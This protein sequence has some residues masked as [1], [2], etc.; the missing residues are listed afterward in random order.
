MKEKIYEDENLPSFERYELFDI[1]EDGL[2]PTLMFSS[3]YKGVR[4]I[5]TL[6]IKGINKYNSHTKKIESEKFLE[7]YLKLGKKLFQLAIS[8]NKIIFHLNKPL[9]DA[10]FISYYIEEIYDNDQALNFNEKIDIDILTELTDYLGD[11]I[12]SFTEILDLRDQL[13]DIGNENDFCK[14]IFITVDLID[15]IINLFIIN[16]TLDLDFSLNRLLD[17]VKKIVDKYY[18]E[19]ALNNSAKILNIFLSAQFDL[20][21]LLEEVEL[22]QK[23]KG[24]ELKKHFSISN[25]T[26][27]FQNMGKI[28]IYNKFEKSP[29]EI[30]FA[31]SQLKDLKRIIINWLNDY[32]F[33]YYIRKKDEA[34]YRKNTG[35]R[36]GDYCIPCNLLITNSIFSYMVYTIFDDWNVADI[37]IKNIFGFDDND[38][39][40]KNRSKIQEVIKSFHYYNNSVCSKILGFNTK[41][42]V[43]EDNEEDH[44]KKV[45]KEDSKFKEEGSGKVLYF[46]NLLLAVNKLIEEK[47]RE[48][49][50]TS[51]K[52][53][54]TCGKVFIVS[55]KN[56]KYCSN[57]CKEK[58]TRKNNAKN[59]NKKYKKRDLKGI[60]K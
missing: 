26:K 47:I 41:E 21:D 6:Y 55:R 51:R 24:F 33:P 37:N 50:N 38:I 59:K 32:G 35:M 1:F 5:D 16:L 58:G 44:E 60:D 8:K 36:D 40:S 29:L 23:N 39:F 2:C 25:N 22:L 10:D 20:N 53:C 54:L 27:N 17:I 45:F 11:Q 30:K 9:D 56:R 19:N 15:D 31:Y 12:N 52:R 28:N 4:D 42:Y 34:K 14:I 43:I 7:D 49:I 18:S 57:V 46:N 13:I 3:D 48:P